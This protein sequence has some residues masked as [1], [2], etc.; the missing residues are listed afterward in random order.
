MDELV[1]E[2]IVCGNVAIKDCDL[3]LS[4]A[5]LF[6]NLLNANTDLS[7][8][9]D[10]FYYL[11]APDNV[12]PDSTMLIYSIDLIDSWDVIGRNNVMDIYDLNINIFA[13]DTSEIDILVKAVRTFLDN[14]S[15]S[16]FKDINLETGGL[17]NEGEREQFMYNLN[18]KITFKE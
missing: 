13:A 6:Y 10:G 9:F 16:H 5:M 2:N 14:Y 1:A 17:D 11:M 3:Q 4:I 8:L 15:D 7:G 12:S 18:Y